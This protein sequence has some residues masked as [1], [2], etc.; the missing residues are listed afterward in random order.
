MDI[1]EILRN[2]PIPNFYILIKFLLSLADDS[3][4]VESTFTRDRNY[5]GERRDIFSGEDSENPAPNAFSEQ[6]SFPYQLDGQQRQ[7]QS[8]HQHHHLNQ[9]YGRDQAIS[10]STFTENEPMNEWMFDPNLIES[11][12]FPEQGNLSFFD[13]DSLCATSRDG[14]HEQNHEAGL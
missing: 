6:S 1:S 3:D 4:L 5:R 2:Y 11:L 12:G 8:E 9:E 14:C 10:L 7:S 13:F